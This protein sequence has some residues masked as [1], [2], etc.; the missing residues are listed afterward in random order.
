MKRIYLAIVMLTLAA[1]ACGAPV[2]AAVGNTPEA[3]APDHIVTANKMVVCN[4]GGVG[5]TIRSA[6]GTEFDRLDEL[7]DGESVELIGVAVVNIRMEMW[8]EVKGGW[9]NAQ[10]LCVE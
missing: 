10:Y 7:Q 8:Q 9:V 3:K 1:L 5:L 6:A 2:T 4:T